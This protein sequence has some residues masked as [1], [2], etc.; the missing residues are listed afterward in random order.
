MRTWNFPLRKLKRIAKMKLR[1]GEE[2]I[3]EE[4]EAFNM[5]KDIRVR[6]GRSKR[7][8]DGRIIEVLFKV[9]SDN[10]VRDQLNRKREV[11][12]DLLTKVSR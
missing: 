8:A 12:N 9:P 7:E 1:R 3:Y 11:R 4:R 6:S 5:P 10:E 2:L